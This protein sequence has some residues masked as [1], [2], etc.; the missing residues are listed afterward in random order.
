MEQH[1]TDGTILESHTRYQYITIMTA[2]SYLEYICHT[3]RKLPRKRLG[4]A[5]VSRAPLGT[6]GTRLGYRWEWGLCVNF[7]GIA[8]ILITGR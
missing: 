7:G 8:L 3:I 1:Q 4:M 5:W 6:L 2:I